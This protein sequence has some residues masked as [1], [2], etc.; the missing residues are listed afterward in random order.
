MTEADLA[1]GLRLSR[2]SGWN[3]TLEDWRLL[4]S[5]GPGLFRVARRE[6][7]RRG[8]GRRRALRRRARLDLHDP[9]R[10]RAARSRPRHADLRRGAAPLRGRG[11]RGSPALRRPGRDP[12]RPRHLPPARLLGR[13]PGSCGMRVGAARPAARSPGRRRAARR[14]RI[15][16]AVLERDRQVFGADR[17]ALLRCAFASAPELA[18]T[19]TARR[20]LLRPS[21]RPLRTTSARSWPRTAECASPWS[22][23]CLSR[24]AQPA[25]DP[26]RASRP[27][28]AGGALASWASASSGRFTRMYLGE[29][30]PLARAGAGARDLRP[31]VRLRMRSLA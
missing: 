11:A 29:A 22:R 24:P 31:G 30:T 16:T 26:G 3:Q 8:L 20:L 7:T 23:A 12:R 27:R 5:L 13:P 17:G 1:D 15:S 14:R 19:T 9:R 6:R 4:L 10:P 2:A 18:W 25:A 28:L 21:R